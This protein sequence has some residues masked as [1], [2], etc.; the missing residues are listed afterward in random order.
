MT[1][2]T[3]ESVF[4]TR[5]DVQAAALFTTIAEQ[6]RFRTVIVRG[7]LHVVHR[8][9]PDRRP[10]GAHHSAR[11]AVDELSR[12]LLDARYL[13]LPGRALGPQRRVG[14]LEGA[15]TRAAQAR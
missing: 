4:M 7:G 11:Q 5:E 13:G 6:P 9:Y 3:S 8:R 1:N 15:S 10:A 12:L 2:R 14:A